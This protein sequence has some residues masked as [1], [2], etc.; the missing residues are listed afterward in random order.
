MCIRDRIKAESK[1]RQSKNVMRDLRLDKVVLNVGGVAEKLEKGFILL[2]TISGKLPVKVKATRRIPTWGVRPGLEVGTKV[3]LRGQDAVA[4]LNRLLPAVDNTLK[5]KQIQNNFLS[6]G[7]HEYIEIPGIEYIREVGIMGFEVTAVFIRA[8]KRVELKRVKR[9]KIRRAVVSK[10]EIEKF[11][12]NKFK[13]TVL[14]KR[15]HVQGE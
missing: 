14:H 12:N 9:G 8:G 4:M 13:T 7:I 15:K 10:E 5:D 11:M 6:F 1:V 2:K 3:T